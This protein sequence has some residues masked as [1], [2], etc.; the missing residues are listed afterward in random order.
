VITGFKSTIDSL[1]TELEQAQTE[2]KFE[3]AGEIQYSLLPALTKK[4][5][6]AEETNVNKLISEE[7]TEKEVAT[8]VGR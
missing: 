4:L 2:G 5:A 3:R 7:V 1:K 6:K 8:I